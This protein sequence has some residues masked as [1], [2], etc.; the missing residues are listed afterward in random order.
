MFAVLHV[1]ITWFDHYTMYTYTAVYKSVQLVCQFKKESCGGLGE[2]DGK[3]E[4]GREKAGS[5]DRA[6]LCGME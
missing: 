1:I 6:Q 2:A 4:V 5:E 3:G